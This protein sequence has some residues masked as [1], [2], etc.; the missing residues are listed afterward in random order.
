MP[1]RSVPDCTVKRGHSL[2]SGG[3]AIPCRQP[4]VQ[5][6]QR[7][8]VPSPEVQTLARTLREHIRAENGAAVASATA[9][10]IGHVFASQ[11]RWRFAGNAFLLAARLNPDDADSMVLVSQCALRLD[12]EGIAAPLLPLPAQRAAGRISFI[13]C[14]ITPSKLAALK[15]NIARLIAADRWEL[16]HIGDAK[17]LAEGYNRGLAQASGELIVL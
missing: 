7:V 8:N 16:I 1:L 15:T 5:W 12:R 11:S 10:Q 17:S 14:S 3:R 9:A 2:S 4:F 6:R 13:V